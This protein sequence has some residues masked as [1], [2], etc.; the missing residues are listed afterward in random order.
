MPGIAHSGLSKRL[1]C[2]PFAWVQGS[3]SNRPLP[4]LHINFDCDSVVKIE[5]YFQRHAPQSAEF[6]ATDKGN[7][8][9]NAHCKRSLLHL[10]IA[11]TL[12]SAVALPVL[13]SSH[14]EAP[15]IAGQQKVDGTDLYL[16]RSYEPGRA[17]FVTVMA[18]YMPFQDPQGG[19][20][21]N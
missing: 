3:K 19:P 18:N 10:A 2:R 21:F 16:F 4:G 12:V 6:K 9:R 14:R 5:I 7:F 1:A 8:M 13:A 20:N 15:F 11:S 17:N